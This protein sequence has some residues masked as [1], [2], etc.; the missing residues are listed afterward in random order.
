[1]GDISVGINDTNEDGILL[2]TILEYDAPADF[3]NGLK[4]RVKTQ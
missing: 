1:M 4:R 2:F 3:A